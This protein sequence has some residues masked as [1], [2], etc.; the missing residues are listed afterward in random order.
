MRSRTSPHSRGPSPRIQGPRRQDRVGPGL[1]RNSPVPPALY[2]RLVPRHIDA[3]ESV[4]RK[5]HDP[6]GRS[7]SARFHACRATA[8]AACRLSD[9]KGRK[10]VLYFYPKADTPGCTKEAIA[11]S[12]LKR[13]IRQ[14][15]HRHPRRFGRPGAGAGQV[16]RQARPEDRARLR[17][18]QEN[19]G[20]PMGFGARS[21][22]TAASSWASCRTTFLIG[23]RR[24]HRAGLGQRQSRRPCRGV[25]E[26]AKAL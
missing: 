13:R 1:A 21:R 6:Q 8:A 2:R 11:F 22:C 19:A 3:C 24:P 26:A 15:R 9:F 25:L 7:E 12:G 16:P 5:A 4:E 14:G 10:L 17:R 23:P 18:N 20:R